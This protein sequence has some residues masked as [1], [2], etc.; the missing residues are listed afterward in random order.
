VREHHVKHHVKRSRQE[1]RRMMKVA[2]ALHPRC[3]RGSYSGGN[4]SSAITIAS[5]RP[6]LA[7]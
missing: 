4:S 6:R 5:S 7:G 2:V 1:R 3:A